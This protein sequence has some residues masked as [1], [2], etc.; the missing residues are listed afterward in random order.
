[1]V[2]FKKF[3]SNNNE[4]NNDEDNSEQIPQNDGDDSFVS[5]E[6]QDNIC[7]LYTSDAAD[8]VRRV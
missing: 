7:L 8:E 4:D 2:F 3:F 5:D 6:D 1:M